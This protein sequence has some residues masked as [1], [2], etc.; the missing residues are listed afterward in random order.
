MIEDSEIPVPTTQ[1]S[2]DHPWQEIQYLYEKSGYWLWWRNQRYRSKPFVKRLKKLVNTCDPKRE[3]VL[4][5][6]SWVLIAHFERD[7]RSEVKAIKNLV[8]ILKKLFV[9]WPNCP[10]YDWS[11]VTDA[12]LQLAAIYSDQMD[13]ESFH[14]TLLEAEDHCQKHGLKPDLE[15]W[16]REF[17][18]KTF[19]VQKL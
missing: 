11:D 4:G 9:V 18:P 15:Q 14:T 7:F 2:F 17:L 16:K 12:L 8:R 3:T 6:E 5:A 19:W 13:F 10:D 1:R